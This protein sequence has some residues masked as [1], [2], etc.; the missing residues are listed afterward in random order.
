[1]LRRDTR[2]LLRHYLEQESSKSDLARQLGVNRDMIHRWIQEGDLE[3]NVD[4]EAVR[5][6]PRQPV[7]T[8]SLPTKPIID[9]RLDEYA[10][11][12]SVRLRGGIF[13]GHNLSGGQVESSSFGRWWFGFRDK[14][15]D[16]VG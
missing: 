16:S 15:I 12:S 2:M 8:S 6:G 14:A 4:A 3:R 5:Y 11:M 1:M 10:E 13:P 7:A 9:A